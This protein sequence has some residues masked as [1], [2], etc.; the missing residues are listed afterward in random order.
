[1]CIRDRGY[2]QASQ[3]RLSEYAMELYEN[4]ADS[5]VKAF[6]VGRGWGDMAQAMPLSGLLTNLQEAAEKFAK[7]NEVQ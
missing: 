1:M 2:A 6:A 5:P 3:Q 7:E 4:Y